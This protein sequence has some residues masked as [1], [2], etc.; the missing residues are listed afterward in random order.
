MN[1]ACSVPIHRSIDRH[2]DHNRFSSPRLGVFPQLAIAGSGH[3]EPQV[4]TQD[5]LGAPSSPTVSVAVSELARHACIDNGAHLRQR[6][7]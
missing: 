6:I 1:F 4:K 7:N 5:K 2:A 3:A